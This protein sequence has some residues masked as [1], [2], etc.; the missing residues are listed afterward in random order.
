MLHFIHRFALNGWL[1]LI[2]ASYALALEPVTVLELPPGPNNPRN[3]E[4]D[5]ITLRDGRILFLYTRFTGGAADDDPADIV[6]RV[7]SDEGQSW[8]KTDEMVIKNDG[9]WNVMSVSLRRLHDGRIA[10]FY[11]RKNSP[12]D[13][14]PLVRFSD[15]EAKSW[16][17]PIEVISDEDKGYFVLNNDRVV[18]LR[19]GRLI[20]PV[21]LHHR[22]DWKKADWTGEIT[23][24]VSDDAGKTWKR[25]AQLQRAFKPTGER[26]AAQEPGIMELT[27]DRLLMWIRTNAGEQYRAFSDDHG[28][29]WTAFE[30]MGVPSPMSPA[31]IERIPGT[32]ELLMVWNDHAQ[33]PLAKRRPRTPFTLAISSDEGATWKPAQMIDSD[34]QGWF[35]YTAIEFAGDHVLLGHVAGKQL[36][37]QELATTRITRIPLSSI[38]GLHSITT[39]S[40]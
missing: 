27:D 13:C 2:T 30:P 19:S 36:P 5:F 18:Q 15:D 23:C 11:L 37:R 3:S 16:S 39:A 6:S 7:S 26:I 10:M 24:Y 12:F 17:E 38:E 4:G 29:H 28:D 22:P 35:C 34:P 25:N 14:R 1:F 9:K 33:V 20:I 40:H 8:S 31:S 32:G 21:A